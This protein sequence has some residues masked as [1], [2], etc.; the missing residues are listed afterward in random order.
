[1]ITAVG[2]L[3]GTGQSALPVGPTRHPVADQG[4]FATL[5]RW[6]GT[7]TQSDGSLEEISADSYQREQDPVAR[8]HPVSLAVVLRHLELI[9]SAGSCTGVRT[10]RSPSF[11]GEEVARIPIDDIVSISRDGVIGSGSSTPSKCDGERNLSEP[12]LEAF[13]F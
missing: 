13:G 7:L 12:S 8:E 10:G 3:S 1:V 9:R 6:A 11:S 5:A 2:R 4:R